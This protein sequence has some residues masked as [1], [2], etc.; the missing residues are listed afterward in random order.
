MGDGWEA[1]MG[2]EDRPAERPV[3]GVTGQPASAPWLDIR[4]GVGY[5]VHRVSAGGRLVLGGVEVPGPIGLEGHSDADVLCHAVMD[6]LL[7]A[8]ALGD[9]GQLFPDTDPAYAGASSLGLLAEVVRRLGAAGWEPW[10]VDAVVVAERPRIAPYVEHM[11]ASLA[12]ALGIDASRVGVKGTTTEGL[13]FEG[14]GSGVGAHAVAIIRA[15][16]H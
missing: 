3:V 12:G 14:A 6:A 15:V 2:A 11:R 7:G 4:I 1:A 9:I 16:A 10:N 8:A 5:D 13:G